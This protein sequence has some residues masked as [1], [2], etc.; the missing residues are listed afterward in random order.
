MHPL[1]SYGL[2]YIRRLTSADPETL[3]DYLYQLPSLAHWLGEIKHVEPTAEKRDLGRR[4]RRDRAA[5]QA[6]AS[7]MRIANYDGLLFAIM[8]QAVADGLRPYNAVRGRQAADARR[9]RQRQRQRRGQ[10]VRGRHPQLS[11]RLTRAKHSTV[12]HWDFFHAHLPPSNSGAQRFSVQREPDL[13]RTGRTTHRA[14]TGR[15]RQGSR[16]WR[17][18]LGCARCARCDRVAR[19]SGTPQGES[20]QVVLIRAFVHFKSGASRTHPAISRE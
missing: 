16:H 11:G 2:A 15:V 6:G 4:P 13:R 9:R 18:S 10:D 1:R 17:R 19:R 12:Q 3:S 8:R 20:D 14:E 7:P 5:P